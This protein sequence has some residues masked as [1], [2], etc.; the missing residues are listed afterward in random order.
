MV[1]RPD[2]EMAFS[3]DEGQTW[4]KPQAF[5]VK[6]VAPCLLTL[7]DGTIA[8]I[9]EWGATGGIQIMWSDD[10]GRNSTTPAKDRG[11]KIDDSVYVYAIYVV[12][13]DPRDNQQKT[14]IWSV[15][16]R[17]REDRSGIDLLPP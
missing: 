8:C 14:A 6:M 11:F 9:F 15:R 1:A 13:Y 4:T 3:K 16:L 2:G 12:D 17:I 10:H 7:K 5:G